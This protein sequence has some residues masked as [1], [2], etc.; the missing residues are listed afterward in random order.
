MG[1][2]SISAAA[3][4]AARRATS[5]LTG[6]GRAWLCGLAAWLAVGAAAAQELRIAVSSGP[7]SLPLYVAQARG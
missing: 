4:G 5:R 3:P 7:V 2:S 1:A 6:L